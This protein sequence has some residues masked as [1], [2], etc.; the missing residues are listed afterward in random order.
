MC[1][2]VQVLERGGKGVLQ[3]RVRWRGFGHGADTWEPLE[4][5]STALDLV[6]DYE[7][8]I[9]RDTESAQRCALALVLASCLATR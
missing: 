9:W 6:S 7:V 5:L 4:G 2:C 1:V 3:Y 8:K